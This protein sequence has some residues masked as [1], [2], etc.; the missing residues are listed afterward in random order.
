M[1]AVIIDCLRTARR[2]S[3][4]RNAS[5]HAAGRSGRDRAYRRCC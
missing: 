1:E 4:E 2:Q 3:P 5:Q